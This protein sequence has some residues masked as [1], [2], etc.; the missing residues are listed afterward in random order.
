MSWI[1]RAFQSADLA[2]TGGM[3]LF[4][5]TTPPALAF[6]W[7]KSLTLSSVLSALIPPLGAL[8]FTCFSALIIP[9][10][11]ADDR[12]GARAV[13]ALPLLYFSLVYLLGNAVGWWMPPVVT[14]AQGYMFIHLWSDLLFVGCAWALGTLVLVFA[15]IAS[16]LGPAKEP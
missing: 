7:A 1:K 13:I 11:T 9:P 15:S 16:K 3:L 4:L 6:V 12:L 14:F 5:S 10:L 8:A 2:F